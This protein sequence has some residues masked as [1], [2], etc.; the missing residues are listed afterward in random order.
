MADDGCLDA[1]AG[2]WPEI[3][4]RGRLAGMQW[5][6]PTRYRIIKAFLDHVALVSEGAYGEKASVLAVRA[7]AAVVAPVR[8]RDA[9]ARQSDDADLA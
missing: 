8:Q 9:D 3:D 7:A 6:N 4:D 2:F 1:S 5:E